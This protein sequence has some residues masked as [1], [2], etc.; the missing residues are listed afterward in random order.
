M[1]HLSLQAKH[2][3]GVLRQAVHGPSQ[4]SSRCLM[5]GNQHGHQVIPQLLAGHLQGM[6]IPEAS[7]AS[8]NT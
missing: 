4:Y 3:L 1:T 5:P 6:D 8:I 7:S 2:N